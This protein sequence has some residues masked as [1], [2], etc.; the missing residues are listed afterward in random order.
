MLDV[1]P[2]HTPAHGVGDFF[3][4]LFTITVGLLIAVG[5]EGMVTRHEHKKLAEEARE[6]LTAEI[7]HNMANTDDAV[8]DIAAQQDRMKKNLDTLEKIQTAPK[9]A[10]A[11][12]ADINAA[13]GSTGLEK[14][15]WRTAQATGALSYMPYEEA[16]RFSGI[17]DEVE[18]FET[19]QKA[20]VEDEA[21]F[22]GALASHPIVNGHITKEG[23]DAM[24]Q[25]FGIWQGHLLNLHIAARVLQEHERAFLEHRAP[26]NHMSEKIGN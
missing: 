8:R 9:G 11:D 5:I 16:Q 14:T 25:R 26:L 10:A 7:R 2:P 20:L 4:H 12:N 15:A 6:T 1:H 3:L 13:Y 18:N 23:A 21:Q 24:A 19:A 17:Y 22:F